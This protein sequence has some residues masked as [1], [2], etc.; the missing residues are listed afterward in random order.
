[1]PSAPSPKIA[2]EV[3]SGTDPGGGVGLLYNVAAAIATFGAPPEVSLEMMN[4]MFK[5]LF[6]ESAE[7]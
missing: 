3:G 2:I 7:Y 5:A 6:A 4:D 1:M